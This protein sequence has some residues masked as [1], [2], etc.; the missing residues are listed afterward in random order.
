MENILKIVF[1]E[2]MILM[3]KLFISFVLIT[4]SKF[5]LKDYSLVMMMSPKDKVFI[6]NVKN[7]RAMIMF[8]IINKQDIIM[9]KL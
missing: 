1:L 8:K 5:Y 3:K 9:K 7:A 4:K 2:R 6:K